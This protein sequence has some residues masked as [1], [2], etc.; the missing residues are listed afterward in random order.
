MEDNMI[1]YS[2]PIGEEN[3]YFLS[4]HCNCIK[5]AKFKDDELLKINGNSIDQYDYHLEKHRP[6]RFENFS[7][8]ICIHSS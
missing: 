1:P 2:I 6:D 4:P 5:G 3:K 8:F 7:E